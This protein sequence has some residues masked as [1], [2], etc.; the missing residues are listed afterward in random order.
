MFMLVSNLG[1]GLPPHLIFNPVD[2]VDYSGDVMGGNVS[3]EFGGL[4][5][6]VAQ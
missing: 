5:I 4:G 6:F 1:R 3:I 2:W